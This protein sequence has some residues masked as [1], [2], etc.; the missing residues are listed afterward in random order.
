M[1]DL[2]N[3]KTE[4][5]SQTHIHLLLNHVAIMAALF[6]AVLFLFG[7]LRKNETIK[8]VALVGFVLAAISVIP[9]YLTGEPAE[10][11]VEHLPGVIESVIESHEEAAE[12]SLWMIE[13]A[14]LAALG[15]LLLK[16][17]SFFRTTVFAGVMV[18]ISLVSASA[19]AYT[20]YLGGQIRHTEI[21]GNAPVQN[22]QQ[23]T[24]QGEAGEEDDD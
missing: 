18:V 16:K 1:V 21:S 24:E 4:S 10:E 22:G 7:A 17:V 2:I 14:G 23:G 13:I 6:S 12:F 15:S 19:I 20:G 5:M 11:S 9:V 3:F 8:N